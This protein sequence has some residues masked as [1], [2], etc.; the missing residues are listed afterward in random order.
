MF[1]RLEI[2]DQSFS[3][4]SGEGT[5]SQPFLSAE[6]LTIHGHGFWCYT[7]V[8][9]YLRLFS[10]SSSAVLGEHHVLDLLALPELTVFNY[11]NDGWFWL[12]FSASTFLSGKQVQGNVN[13]ATS[14]LKR[15][16]VAVVVTV[17]RVM[18]VMT[19]VV[20]R[21]S[22]INLVSSRITW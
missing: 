5:S 1:W 7:C 16:I 14:G 6:G 12:T 21:V 10:T 15:V 18:M 3:I 13:S 8:V 4:G 22:F 19:V 9:L 20:M 11:Y 17:V 2:R